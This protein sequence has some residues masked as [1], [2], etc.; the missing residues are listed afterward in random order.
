MEY[1][2][3]ELE[4]EKVIVKSWVAFVKPV[5]VTLLLLVIVY[6]A[7]SNKAAINRSFVYPLLQNIGVDASYRS[8][9]FALLMLPLL[10]MLLKSAY[11]VA[12]L[13]TYRM[14]ITDRGVYFEGGILPWKKEE[15][16]WG[17]SQIYEAL[18]RTESQ[19]LGWLLTFGT[20]VIVGREGS[21]KEYSITHMKNPRE[22]SGLINERIHQSGQG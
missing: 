1:I 21:T 15:R 11:S 4:M 16:H 9:T 19:F 17:Y 6:L 5:F 18:Y 7:L 20:I 22:V 10:L 3:K 13:R 8:M 2:D 12:L 14:T